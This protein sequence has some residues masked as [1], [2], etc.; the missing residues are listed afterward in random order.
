MIPVTQREGLE[1]AV[2]AV[3][4][5]VVDCSNFPGAS[6]KDTQIGIEVIL[7]PS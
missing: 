6:G 3:V 7:Y 5:A 1:T 4:V 2:V